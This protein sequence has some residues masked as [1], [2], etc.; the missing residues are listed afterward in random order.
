[1]TTRTRCLYRQGET[2]WEETAYVRI[3]TLLVKWAAIGRRRHKPRWTEE[4][5][6]V[7]LALTETHLSPELHRWN[8]TFEELDAVVRA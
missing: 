7:A 8:G 1:M 4:Q 2:S 5:W 6:R 3:E